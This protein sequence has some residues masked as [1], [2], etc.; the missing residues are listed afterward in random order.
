MRLDEVQLF[1]ERARRRQLLAMFGLGLRH[2]AVILDSLRFFEP[3]QVAVAEIET[4]VWA[5]GQRL[6]TVTEAK[7]GDRVVATLRGV[8]ASYDDEC[9][10]YRDLPK[11]VVRKLQSAPSPAV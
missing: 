10:C 3:D 11:D 2:L 6:I 8:L 1:L 5:E 4:R 9:H 7:V